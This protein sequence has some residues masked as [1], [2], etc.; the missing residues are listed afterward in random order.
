MAHGI[1]WGSK[2]LMPAIACVFLGQALVGVA[3]CRRRCLLHCLFQDTRRCLATG[4]ICSRRGTSADA[5]GTEAGNEVELFQATNSNV[6]IFILI[7][8]WS[9]ELCLEYVAIIFDQTGNNSKDVDTCH[10]HFKPH[11]KP[12]FPNSSME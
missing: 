3:S 2:W 6:T 10:K 7:Y 4:A 12:H 1:S 8:Y 9:Y 11:F 5:H